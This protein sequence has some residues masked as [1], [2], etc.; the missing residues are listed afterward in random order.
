MLLELG[1]ATAA[2]LGEQLNLSTAAIRRHLD[3]MLAAGSIA[4]VEPSG[5]LR[6]GRGRPARAFA[7]TEIGR[8]SFPHAYDVLAASAL[9][10]MAAQLGESAVLQ[11]AAARSSELVTRYGGRIVGDSPAA[12][13][14]SLAAALTEDGYAAT[15][16]DGEVCQHH[17]PVQHVAER[18]P[19]LCD[20]ET[21]AFAQLLGEPVRRLTTIAHGESCCTA[22][23]SRRQSI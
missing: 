21:E 19:Q 4:A 15:A 3:A 9:D 16:V 11:F 7:L 6:R 8:D 2:D 5:L 13:A 14:E 17:C 22:S 10:F 23:I 20:A 12:R 18:F 1:Q